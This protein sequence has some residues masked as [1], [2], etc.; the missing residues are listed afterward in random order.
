MSLIP[1]SPLQ[2]IQ[3]AASPSTVAQA[4]FETLSLDLYN[5]TPT[6][7]N[8]DPT[9]VIGAPTS[10]TFALKQKWVDAYGATFLCTVAGT[11]GTWRQLAPVVVATLPVSGTIPTGYQ[12][13]DASDNYRQ[14]FHAGSFVWTPVYEDATDGF[15]MDD[16][17]NIAV[18]SGTGTKIATATTQKLGFWNA[19]PVV[20]PAS[21]NQGSVTLSGSNPAAYNALT[22]SATVTQAEAEAFRDLVSDT[23][24]DIANLHTLLEA[25]RSAGVTTGLIKGSA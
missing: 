3:G 16:G 13:L 10:G 22:F 20:Q 23:A 7:Q 8:G 2:N 6:R 11:P 4:N 18:G 14:F 12:V 15:T 19:T 1:N 25:L 9:T 5:F 21:A 24:Q 17:A